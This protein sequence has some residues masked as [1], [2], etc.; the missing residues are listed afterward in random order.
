MTYREKLLDPRWQKKRL[1]IFERDEWTCLSCGSKDENLQVHH[2]VYAKRDPWDYADQLLQ[3]LCWKCH[4][5]RQVIS[6]K[7][8][9]ALRIA[10]K[11]LPTE[12]MEKRANE[13]IA[14][15][16]KEVG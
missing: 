14:T 3:T 1:Q 11:D 7:A 9:N 10:I 6:E 2:V 12:R 16:L 15:A 5:E 8:A 4:Q 13:I